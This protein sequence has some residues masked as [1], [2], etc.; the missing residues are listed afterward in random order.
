V[1]T[2]VRGHEFH[3][4]SLVPQGELTYVGTVKDAQGRE[5]GQDGLTQANVMAL[6]AHLHFLTQPAIAR[7]LVQMAR[8]YSTPAPNEKV[9]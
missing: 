1:G 3:Y 8:E 5:C 9:G 6:Y 2:K 7:N 4:S